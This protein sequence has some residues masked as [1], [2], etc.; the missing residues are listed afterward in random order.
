MDRQTDGKDGQGRTQCATCTVVSFVLNSVGYMVRFGVLLRAGGYSLL[1]YL[2]P[3]SFLFL[4]S[5]LISLSPL[6]PHRLYN[7]CGFLLMVLLARTFSASRVGRLGLYCTFSS[8][9]RTHTFPSRAW[10]FGTGLQHFA[11]GMLDFWFD[12]MDFGNVT[13]APHRCC[14]LF[15]TACLCCTARLSSGRHERCQTDNDQLAGGWR[16]EGTIFPRASKVEEDMPLPSHSTPH[17]AFHLFAI[18]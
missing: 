8:Y 6:L 3:S 16:Q 9:S 15:P 14:Y 18:C 10:R 7:V 17:Y 13:S 1:R 11:A 5:S 12:G 2:A 4:P